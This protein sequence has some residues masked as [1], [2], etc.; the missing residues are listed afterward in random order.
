M[1][2]GM[3]H[4]VINVNWSL[5]CFHLTFVAPTLRLPDQYASLWYEKE[6]EIEQPLFLIW[7]SE[8]LRQ[9]LCFRSLA[10]C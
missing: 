8:W 5:Y 1:C 3:F 7:I 10:A 9:A 4:T 6:P 2:R